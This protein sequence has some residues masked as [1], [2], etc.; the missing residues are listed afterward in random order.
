MTA[1]AEKNVSV[2][3][4]EVKPKSQAKRRYLMSGYKLDILKQADLCKGRAGAV[5]ELLRKEGLY[6]SHLTE[7]RRQRDSG[8]LSAL[9]P[10]RGRKPKEF[11]REMVHGLERDNKRLQEQLRQA[12]LIIKAQKKIS[13]LLQNGIPSSAVTP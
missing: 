12:G 7:W 2:P 5:G 10:K 13:E 6:S 8:S 11:S 9:S 1:S 3:D 4:I